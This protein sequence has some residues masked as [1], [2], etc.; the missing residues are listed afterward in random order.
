MCSEITNRPCPCNGAVANPRTRYHKFVILTKRPNRIINFS[1]WQDKE[2]W[3]TEL[4]LN[5]LIFMASVWDQ[6][7]CNSACEAFSRLPSGCQWGL[8]IEPLLA[9]IRLPWIDD[10]LVKC[11]HGSQHCSECFRWE[12]CDNTTPHP[13]W[14]CV[15]GENATNARPCDPHWIIDIKDQCKIAG[16]PFWFKS[17]GSAAKKQKIELRDMPREYPEGW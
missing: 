4:F 3:R 13:S 5:R 12:C 9:P 6:D 2:P 16:V 10:C 8:H 17:L 1:N 11:G 7:S 14:V 15:G